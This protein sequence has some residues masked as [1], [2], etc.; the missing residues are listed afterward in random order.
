MQLRGNDCEDDSDGNE[1]IQVKPR[2]RVPFAT[3]TTQ[4]DSDLVV[5]GIQ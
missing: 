5:K 4:D 2:R 3:M 1:V